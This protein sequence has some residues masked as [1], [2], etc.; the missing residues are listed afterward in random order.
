MIEP[1]FKWIGD[2]LSLL[3]PTFLAA[4]GGG[5]ALWR[6]WEDQKWRRVQY[7]QKLIKEFFDNKGTAEVC[8]ILDTIDETVTL[9]AEDD[10]AKTRDIRITDGF[11]RGALSTFCQKLGNT[12]E[13]Q[14]IRHLFDQFFDGL[15][16]FQNHIEIRLIKLQDVKPYLEYWVTELSGNGKIRSDEAAH[17]IRRYLDCFG[18]KNVVKLAEDMG[19]PIPKGLEPKALPFHCYCASKEKK[20]S[21]SLVRAPLIASGS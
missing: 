5:F 18:Y 3:I 15:G 19:Y 8:D 11:L 7:A 16:M 6:W 14:H 1:I 12:D 2:N 9:R 4:F 17:Q 20:S 21:S 13:E 10:P